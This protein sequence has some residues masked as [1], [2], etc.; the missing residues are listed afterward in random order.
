VPTDPV[1]G[2]IM[3]NNIEN[4]QFLSKL[5]KD[6]AIDLKKSLNKTTIY[7]LYGFGALIG[8]LISFAFSQDEI[9]SKSTDEII[10]SL[11]GQGIILALIL[12]TMLILSIPPL[13]VKKRFGKLCKDHNI[14]KNPASREFGRLKLK[15]I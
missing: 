12:A 7:P 4:T 6:E 15:D 8:F 1:Q 3:T 14:P 5:P 13:R 9:N 11:I 10:S 2:E